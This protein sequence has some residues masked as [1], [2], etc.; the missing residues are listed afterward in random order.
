MTNGESLSRKGCERNF[1]FNFQAIVS[2]ML[3]LKSGLVVDWLR[4]G[5]DYE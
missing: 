3:E 4:L 5:Y 1:F 2:A